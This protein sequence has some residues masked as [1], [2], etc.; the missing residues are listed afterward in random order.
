M[1]WGG[2]VNNVNIGI[3]NEVAEVVICLY[4]LIKILLG[5]GN[6][7]IQV[8]LVY[9]AYSNQPA[10]LV[11]GEMVTGTSYTAYTDD[12]TCKLITGSNKVVGS[13]HL[14]QHLAGQDAEQ[15]RCGSCPF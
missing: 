12:T 9:I 10:G 5:S 1:G 14:T 11:T 4:G 15:C 8:F 7:R 13:T 3:V 6:G 2:N